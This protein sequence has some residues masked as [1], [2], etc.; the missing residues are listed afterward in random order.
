MI[1]AGFGRDGLLYQGLRQSWLQRQLFFKLL[2]RDFAERYRGSYLGL[3]WSLLLPLMSLLVFTFFFGVIFKIRWA[4][5]GNDSLSDLALI[6]FVGITLY[7]F[8]AECLSRAP[9]LILAH[10]NYVKNVIFP[11]EILPVVMVASALLT[12]IV[13]LL[14]IV[15]LQ[16]TM[17]QGLTWTI[18]LL[19]VVI[20]PLA[21]FVLGLSWFLA[22][23]GVYIRDIQQLIVPVVQFMMFLSPVFYPVS[24]L[25]E[26]IRPWLNINPLALVIEQTRGIVLFGRPLDW[27][28]YLMCLGAGLATALLGAYW[29]ARTRKGFA[30]VL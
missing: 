6:L 28:A 19:P 8:F 20:A 14:I 24:A 21:L 29:F 17:G 12:L 16:A 5:L 25:P 10:Q 11:L 18:L 9:G 22:A 3:L 23:L 27:T 15:V 2:R 26:S 1:S 7:N 4:G 30:D 13:T